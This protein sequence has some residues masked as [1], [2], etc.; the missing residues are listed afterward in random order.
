M[1]TKPF[2]EYCFFYYWLV[3]VYFG[4]PAGHK[5]A[6]AFYSK[7]IQELNREVVLNHLKSTAAL[8]GR[9][10][11]RLASQLAADAMGDSSV[12]KDTS[13]PSKNTNLNSL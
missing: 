3:F 10:G 7:S 13:N 4:R 5:A 6:D 12:S 1:K 11:R 9:A 2:D 8:T